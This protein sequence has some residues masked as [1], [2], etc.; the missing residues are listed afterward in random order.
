M[1]FNGTSN[2]GSGWNAFAS[3]SSFNYLQNPNTVYGNTANGKFQ[4]NE[5]EILF[6]RD[7]QLIQARIGGLSTS[8]EQ[9]DF[10]LKPIAGSMQDAMSYAVSASEYMSR[11]EYIKAAEQRKNAAAIYVNE[12]NRAFPSAVTEI[13]LAMKILVRAKRSDMVAQL[14]DSAVKLL[15]ENN[16]RELADSVC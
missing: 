10:T 11:G 13:N 8:T 3:P 1:S 2:V 9:P 15:E 7:M 14:R 6:N 5:D 4:N 16:C 12:R